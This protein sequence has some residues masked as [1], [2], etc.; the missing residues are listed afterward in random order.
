MI[1]GVS[2]VLSSTYHYQTIGKVERFHKFMENSL[3][4]IIKSDR[5]NWPD[6]LDACLFMYRTTL[7][8]A[9]NEIPF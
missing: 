3:S 7:N 6:M 2:H 1:Y 9:L 4:T 8:Q 5:T